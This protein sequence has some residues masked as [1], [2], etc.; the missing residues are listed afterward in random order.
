MQQSQFGVYDKIFHSR[1]Q[2]YEKRTDDTQ[3]RVNLVQTG[4]EDPDLEASQSTLRIQRA[5]ADSGYR[6]SRLAPTYASQASAA[7]VFESQMRGSQL[8]Q[9]SL[10]TSNVP[11]VGFGSVAYSQAPTQMNQSQSQPMLQSGPPDMRPGSLIM[12][13]NMELFNQLNVLT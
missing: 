7:P 2:Y 10:T 9:S 11:Q 4:I 5:P 12:L 1:T 3:S 8:G 6:S 13:E